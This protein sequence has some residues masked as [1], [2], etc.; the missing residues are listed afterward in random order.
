MLSDMFRAVAVW[1]KGPVAPP[2]RQPPPLERP[3]FVSPPNVEWVEHP[4]VVVNSRVLLFTGCYG[5]DKDPFR[6]D[7]GIEYLC[8]DD[9]LVV[10]PSEAD[11]SRHWVCPESWGIFKD[12]MGQPV[13]FKLTI[14][15]SKG[16]ASFKVFAIHIPSDGRRFRLAELISEA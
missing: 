14:G 4:V 11:F 8:S 7:L 5:T 9:Y 3:R 2:P 15:T 13:G 1:F 6:H 12:L 10:D 16:P